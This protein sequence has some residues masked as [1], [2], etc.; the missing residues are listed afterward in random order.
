MDARDFLATFAGTLTSSVI[1]YVA[2]RFSSSR[3]A[4]EHQC[5]HEWS[6]FEGPVRTTLAHADDDGPPFD[7]Y[8]QRH[9]CFKCGL[10][11][12]QRIL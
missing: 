7:I 2:G 4:R 8:E 3:G 12:W 10:V 1:G 9:T 6:R 11:T 5:H